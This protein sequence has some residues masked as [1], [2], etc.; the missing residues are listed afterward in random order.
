MTASQSQRRAEAD[1]ELLIITS[2]QIYDN[3][4]IVDVEI[5]L[6]RQLDAKVFCVTYRAVMQ[7][8]RNIATEQTNIHRHQT[9]S[10][11]RHAAHGSRC[12]VQRPRFGVAPI[13]AKRDVILKTGST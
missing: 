13:T 4:I 11:Y 10:R 3:N 5:K 6:C 8:L 2:G 9:P 1:T 7:T 12:T